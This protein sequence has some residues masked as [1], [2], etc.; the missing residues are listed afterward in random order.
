MN[1][2]GSWTGRDH[3]E[4]EEEEEEEEA[5]SEINGETRGRTKE[6]IAA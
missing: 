2:G 3:E 6:A 4:S 1:D 5:A